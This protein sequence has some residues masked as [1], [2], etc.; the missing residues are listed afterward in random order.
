M[1]LRQQLD[2]L[3]MAVAPLLSLGDTPLAPSQIGLSFAVTAWVAD[4]RAIRQRGERFQAQ[5][6]PGLLAGRRER[7]ERHLS[8]GEAGVPGVG[9]PAD[10]DGPEGAL[11]RAAPA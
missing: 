4:H 7:V 2:R 10:R 6:D 11:N 1:C 8:A 3:A 5:V 9:F